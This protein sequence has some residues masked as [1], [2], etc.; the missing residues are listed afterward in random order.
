M[1][2]LQGAKEVKFMKREIPKYTL[3]C[4]VCGLEYGEGYF[5]A[6]INDDFTELRCMNCGALTVKNKAW[7]NISVPAITV[8]YVENEN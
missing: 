6:H 3:E 8:R 2:D 7:L 1:P 5:T 4:L